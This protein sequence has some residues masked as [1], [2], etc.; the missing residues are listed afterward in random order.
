MTDISLDE[1]KTQALAILSDSSKFR[2]VEEPIAHDDG[3]LEM[4][5]VELSVFFK[6]YREVRMIYGDMV[7]DR[8]G[9]GPSEIDQQ[10]LSIGRDTEH[11][12]LAVRKGSDVVLE[13]DESSRDGTPL[14]EYQSVYHLILERDHLI[15]EG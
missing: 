2:C 7:L 15:H 4:L 13:I 5:G 12:E 9:I 11:A 1:A 8:D 6:K 14:A 10:F 3:L